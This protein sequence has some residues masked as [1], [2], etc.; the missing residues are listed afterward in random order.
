[1]S[2]RVKCPICGREVGDGQQPRE[3]RRFFPFCSERCRAMDLGRWV[4]EEYR[5]SEPL[6]PRPEETEES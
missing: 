4:D 3:G 1:M 6:L 5:V 2:E